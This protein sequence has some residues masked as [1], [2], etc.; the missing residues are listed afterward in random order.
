MPDVIAADTKGRVEHVGRGLG[1]PF[2]LGSPVDF[3][4]TRKSR[5]IGKWPSTWPVIYRFEPT[6]IRGGNYQEYSS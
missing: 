5:R 2:S 1:H 6:M 4:Q 3:V